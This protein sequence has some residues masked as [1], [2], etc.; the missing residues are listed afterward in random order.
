MSTHVPQGA[1]HLRA[2]TATTVQERPFDQSNQAAPDAQF[3]KA[4]VWADERTGAAKGM[5]FL[6]K[7]VFPDH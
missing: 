5:R 4:L 2:D 3:P 6:L 1:D 7:K